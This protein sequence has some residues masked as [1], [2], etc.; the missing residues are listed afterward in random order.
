MGTFA[1]P[2]LLAL[3]SSY[4]L[5]FLFKCLYGLLGRSFTPTKIIYNNPCIK[6]FEDTK[7]VIR[8]YFII[9]LADLR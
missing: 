2:R 5:S 6:I 4:H 7:L 8:C 3:I 9:Y 1:I